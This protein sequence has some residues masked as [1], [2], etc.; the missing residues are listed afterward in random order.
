MKIIL[1]LDYELFFG[2]KT[3]SVSQTI[4]GA[5]EKLLEVVDEF[6]IKAVFFVDVGFL[7]QLKYHKSE[8]PELEEDYT[9][10]SEQLKQL[11]K[12]GHDLQLHVHPHWEDSY[13]NN[14][15][16]EINADRYKLSDWSDEKVE[17]IV[18][19]YKELLEQFCIN[20]TV[21]AYRAGGFCIQP[22]EKIKVALKKNNIWL[23]S[24]V[25]QGGYNES[26]THSF[27]FKDT[28][29]Q[30]EWRFQND[31]LEIAENGC[32][33]ELPISSY[34]VSPLFYWKLAL[35]RLTKNSRHQSFGN[36]NSLPASNKWLIKKLSVPSTVCAS[37]DGY[38]SS[39]LNA[40]FEHQEQQ[41]GSNNTFV[42]IGHPKALSPYSLDK[43]KKFIEKNIKSHQFET[44]S[45]LVNKK[46]IKHP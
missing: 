20:K 39:F 31:P 15:K 1:T 41:Y 3:G 12:E 18:K 27:N 9:L 28:P 25:F 46:E 26:K 13:Y 43:L 21:F 37:I 23:D 29:S 34:K 33:L 17:D 32:F 16:W 35:T 24:T 22:F 19:E 6:N 4:V 45:A 8:Y 36:G 30:P 10:I 38:K 40:A 2:E 7:K 11:S 5:T 42:I 14:G 44:F